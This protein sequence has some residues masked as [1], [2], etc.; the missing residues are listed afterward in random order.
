MGGSKSDSLNSLAR[1]LWEWCMKRNIFISAQHIPGHMN[2]AAD[3]LSRTFSYNLEW[4]L[5]TNVFQQITQLALVPD[6]DL[7]ASSLNAKLSRFVSWHPK[8][9]AE[10]VNAFSIN[11]SNL[12]CY[13]FP[14]FSLLPRVLRKISVDKAL[15]LLIAPVWTTQ[16]WYSLLLQLLVDKPILLPRKD[17]LLFQPHSSTLH[18]MKDHLVL[19]A[20]KLSE[21]PLETEAILTKQPVSLPHLGR[22]GPINNTIQ[23]GNSGVAGVHRGKLI[24]FNHL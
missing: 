17:T 15:V 4:S 19:A 2:S 9:G 5:N 11:C 21:N 7:F 14:P 8:P 23:H 24:L 13:A 3:Q 22:R 20:W 18:P 6:I 1:L 16:S 10:A 12:K